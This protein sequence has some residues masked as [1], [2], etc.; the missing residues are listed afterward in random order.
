MAT[1]ATVVLFATARL[2][3]GRPQIAW[4][5]TP[6]GTTVRSLLRSLGARYPKLAPILATCRFV[7]NGKYVASP[8]TR[9]RPGDEFAVHPP[10][11][12]G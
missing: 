9:V 6:K 4:S 2:A 3:V 5:V 8:A 12:G 7:L 11:G 1:K 10:Y